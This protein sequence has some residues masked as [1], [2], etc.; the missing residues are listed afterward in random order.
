MRTWVEQLV[1][2]A[3]HVKDVALQLL[4]ESRGVPH[5]VVGSTV[6][7]AAD[8]MGAYRITMRGTR[9]PLFP[10][11]AMAEWGADEFGLEPMMYSAGRYHSKVC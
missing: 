10:P 5:A 3:L 11:K 9:V 6:A 2:Y 1:R 7:E 4:G 8:S